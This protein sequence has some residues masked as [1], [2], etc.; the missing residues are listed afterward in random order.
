MNEPNFFESPGAGGSVG[1][2]LDRVDG[3]DKVTGKARYSAEFP[4]PGLTYG[5]L[6]TSDVA[7]GKITRIDTAAAAKEPGVIAV[8]THLNLPKL[9]QTPNTPEGKKAIGAPMGFMPLTGD[10]IHYAGQPVALIVADTFER[11]THAASLVRVSYQTAPTISSFLDPKAE[12][13]D[14]LKVQ[15]GKTP[16][17]TR[18]G[19]PQAALAASAVQL[20]ATYNT[21]LIIT[22]RWNQARPRPIGKPPT[23]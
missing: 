4:L 11:A 22:T 14:P 1:K 13:F 3:R 2:P 15:D 16:G 19:D 21:P 7:K 8:L 5:V 20:K 10:E 23:G 6:K 9:A 12:I 18:R 17:H